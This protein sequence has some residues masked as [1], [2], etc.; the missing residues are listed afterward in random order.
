MLANQV[1]N[2]GVLQKFISLNNFIQGEIKEILRNTELNYLEY[3]ILIAISQG[4][5]TQYKISKEYNISIQN[6][7]RIIKLLLKKEY[8]TFEERLLNGRVSKFLTIKPEVEKIIENV[9]NKIADKLKTKK[10]KYSELIKFNDI[11]K[12]FLYELSR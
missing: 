4:I 8:I 1:K 5:A 9:N 6:S 2:G 3:S 12:F 10:I 11:L 7:H